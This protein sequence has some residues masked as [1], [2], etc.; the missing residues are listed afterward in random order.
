MAI[1]TTILSIVLSAMLQTGIAPKGHSVEDVA[2]M[3]EAVFFEASNR[4]VKEKEAVAS[5]I[6]N[7]LESGNYG[8]SVCQVTRQKGQF[9]FQR[10]NKKK[11]IVPAQHKNILESSIIAL[12]ALDGSVKDRTGGAT[13]FVNLKIATDTDWLR[14]MKKIVQ[15]G[16]H[17]FYAPKKS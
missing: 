17:T 10:M 15:I 5:V 16:P 12:R 6:L 11:F 3:T 14:N 7:R 13:H 2:C 9:S 4:P 1:N 8:N